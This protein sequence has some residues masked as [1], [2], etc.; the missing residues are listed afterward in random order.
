MAQFGGEGSIEIAVGRARCFEIAADVERY[1]EWHTLISSMQ[2]L[3]QQ[4][5]ASGGS[6]RCRDDQG[7]EFDLYQPNAGY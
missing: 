6:A 3:D 4:D 5:Y 2:V 7:V 1:P